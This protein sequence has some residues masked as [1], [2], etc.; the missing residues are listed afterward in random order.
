MEARERGNHLISDLI[1][2]A[3]EDAELFER[4][5]ALC[6]EEMG[7][8]ARPG[9]AGMDAVLAGKE[10][11]IRLIDARAAQ[12]AP[13]WDRLWGGG[14]EEARKPELLERVEGIRRKIEEIQR[15]E[16]E[17]ARAVAGR[18]KGARESVSSLGRL[19]QAMDAYR[20]ARVYDPRFVDRKE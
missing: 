1:R 16:A 17:I 13:L 2:R 12:A 9:L 7:C 10:S 6:Q 18:R 11:L 3:D 8:L 14:G 19:G 4:L 15:L 5:R 20:P